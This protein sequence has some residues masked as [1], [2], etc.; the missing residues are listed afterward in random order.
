MKVKKVNSFHKVSMMAQL[1][2][3]LGY[4]VKKIDL[5]GFLSGT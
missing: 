5:I 1:Y 4:F 2:K 3:D